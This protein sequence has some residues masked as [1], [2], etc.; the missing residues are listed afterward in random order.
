M[1]RLRLSGLGAALLAL[2]ASS[3]DG[4]RASSG[5]C[6]EGEQCADDTPEGLAFEGAQVSWFIGNGLIP[7]AAGGHQTVRITDKVTELPFELPFL[8]TVTNLDDHGAAVA[9]EALARIEASGEGTG[10]LRIARV[11][12]NYLFDRVAIES[13][14][15]ERAAVR[16]TMNQRWPRIDDRPFALWAG[17]EAELSVALLAAGDG[18]LADE[19]LQIATSSPSQPVA[20]DAVRV[21]APAAAGE[22][23]VGIG[24]G[25]GRFT[26]T[27]TVPVVDA[28]TAVEAWSGGGDRAVGAELEVCF[29]AGAGAVEVHGVRW[30]FDL[31]GP[32]EPLPA[33]EQEYPNCVDVR[34]TGPGTA[35]VTASAGGQRATTTYNVTG[36][37]ARG[38][39][40]RGARAWPWAGDRREPGERA[41][42]AE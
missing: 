41:L 4:Q 24:A 38:V 2:A 21:T 9:G 17:G 15:I 35:S 18:W 22:L 26:A 37:S 20:W 7:T 36:S 5:W 27:A 33:A 29:V 12:D 39:V 14:A 11:Q 34:L 40:E 30:A 6:P 32:V 23:T 19:S 16:L 13:K 28:L 10:H 8:A 25:G 1:T 31:I 42:R 3:T